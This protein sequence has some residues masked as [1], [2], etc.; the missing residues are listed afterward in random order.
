MFITQDGS[1]LK[2]SSASVNTFELGLRSAFGYSFLYKELGVI[3]T[4][5]HKIHSKFSRWRSE[6]CSFIEE[7]ISPT[8]NRD[9]LDRIALHS[10]E[11]QQK[12][13]STCLWD[14]WTVFGVYSFV[15]LRS[16]EHTE[17]NYKMLIVICSFCFSI[18]YHRL[19]NT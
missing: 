11:A 2:N 18:T 19:Q 8:A 1:L 15:T 5:N 17:T 10:V 7:F 14:R 4:F 12:C 13:K 6:P 16:L 3:S 9:V